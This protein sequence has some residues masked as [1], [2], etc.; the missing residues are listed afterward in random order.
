MFGEEDGTWCACMKS[1][2]PPVCNEWATS[3]RIKQEIDR[4]RLL[5]SLKS[6][7]SLLYISS[8]SHVASVKPYAGRCKCAFSK[9]NFFIGILLF[10]LITWISSTGFSRQQGMR[11]SNSIG[12]DK[13]TMFSE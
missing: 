8:L 6:N 13:S 7:W 12:E 2:D 9:K 11:G 4:W 5:D 3:K 10:F 1:H